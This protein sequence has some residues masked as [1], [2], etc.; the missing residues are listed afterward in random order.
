MFTSRYVNGGSSI[1]QIVEIVSATDR[2]SGE[3]GMVTYNMSGTAASFLNID[4]DRGIIRTNKG[5][6][7]INQ[8]YTLTVIVKDKGDPPKQTSSNI[9]V[10]FQAIQTQPVKFNQ[11]LL[12]F[13]ISENNAIGNRIGSIRNNVLHPS[14]TNVLFEIID[15]VSVTAFSINA[16]TG[17]ITSSLTLDR[18]VKD[19]HEFVV[20]AK[21][22]VNGEQSDLSVVRP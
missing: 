21:N 5:M 20:K 18:E 4:P 16:S 7:P 14:G 11:E 3:N 8:Q 2:D 22:P 10:N 1:S 15:T 6:V 9:N 19:N 17:I 13:T 12:E